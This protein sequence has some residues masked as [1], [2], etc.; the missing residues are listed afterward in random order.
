MPVRRCIRRTHPFLVTSVLLILPCL[1][2]CQDLLLGNYCADSWN[3]R[4]GF[5]GLTKSGKPFY[6]KRITTLLGTSITTATAMARQ[7]QWR[8][9]CGCWTMSGLPLPEEM[10]WRTMAHVCFLPPS[11]L[12]SLESFKHTR[13]FFRLISLRCSFFLL[14]IQHDT[15]LSCSGLT[16]SVS[17]PPPVLSR[18][19]RTLHGR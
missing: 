9:R 4:W 15:R 14:C 17:L 11:P 8:D 3:G 7:G 13:Y 5:Q 18:K 10:T 6:T 2:W 1:V 16:S 12:Q 19:V